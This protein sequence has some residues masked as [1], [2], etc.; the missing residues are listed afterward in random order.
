[1]SGLDKAPSIERSTD[2]RPFDVRLKREE[3]SLLALVALCHPT[4][5]PRPAAFYLANPTLV[6]P[7]AHTYSIYGYT[8]FTLSA[9]GGTMFGKDLGVHPMH[10]GRGHGVTLMRARFEIAKAAGCQS[11]VGATATD[12]AS[13][14]RLFERFGLMKVSTVRGMYVEEDPIRDGEMWAVAIAE[15]AL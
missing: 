14:L 6:L 11:F 2:V 13:M 12:N 3:L 4:R 1:M 5:R 7:H 8:S 9:D 10:R 15:L